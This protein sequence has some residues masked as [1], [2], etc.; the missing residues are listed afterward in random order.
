MTPRRGDLTANRIVDPN[1]R[2]YSSNLLEAGD[3]ILTA[4]SFSNLGEGV[5]LADSD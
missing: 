5:E 3:R 1:G 2:G 4:T